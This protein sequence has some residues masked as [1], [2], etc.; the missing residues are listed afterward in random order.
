L[1]T[2]REIDTTGRHSLKKVFRSDRP[3]SC[4]MC[5]SHNFSLGAA[6]DFG[7]P[8]G[9]RK[10]NGHRRPK[11]SSGITPKSLP[12]HMGMEKADIAHWR[13]SARSAQR[14]QRELAGRGPI[15]NSGKFFL[16]LFR[17]TAAAHPDPEFFILTDRDGTGRAREQMLLIPMSASD[18][19]QRELSVIEVSDFFSGGGLWLFRVWGWVVC[20]QFSA[21]IVHPARK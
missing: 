8:L 4:A 2:P 5:L 19:V 3:R 21:C 6:T 11:L 10:S 14:R 20:P 9:H 16:L 12:P 7:G 13:Q 1:P 18:S 17:R 15:V